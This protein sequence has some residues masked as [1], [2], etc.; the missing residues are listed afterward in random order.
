M[1]MIGEA[2]VLFYMYSSGIPAFLHP[3]LCPVSAYLCKLPLQPVPPGGRA[4]LNL[5]VT[6]ELVQNTSQAC[7]GLPRDVLVLF[8]RLVKFRPLL[9]LFPRSEIGLLDSARDVHDLLGTQVERLG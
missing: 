1:M 2:D 4:P 7:I 6:F 3:I 8:L 5:A 9:I